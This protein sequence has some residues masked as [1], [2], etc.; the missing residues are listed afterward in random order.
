MYITD[1]SS[2]RTGL[3][4]SVNFIRWLLAYNVVV[5]LVFTMIYKNID[6][7]KHFEVPPDFQNSFSEVAYYSF[8]CVVQMY[9]TNIVPKTTM[10]RSI[11]SIQSFLT[12][13]VFIVMLA[14]WSLLPLK[15]Q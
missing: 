1:S 6:F 10:G 5:W 12:Y 8:Q 13:S 7:A 15:S 9:G 4:V 14:P 3:L 2:G 11:V